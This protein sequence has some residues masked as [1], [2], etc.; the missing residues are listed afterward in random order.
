VHDLPV[1]EATSTMYLSWWIIIVM[2]E[3]SN[4]TDK[5]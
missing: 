2:P 5:Q 4:L 3:L 1:A